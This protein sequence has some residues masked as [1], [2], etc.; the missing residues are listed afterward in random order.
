MLC[1]RWH[2]YWLPLAFFWQPLAVP[3]C[4]ITPHISPPLSLPLPLSRSLHLFS[5]PSPSFSISLSLSLCLSLPLSLILNSL[6]VALCLCV[7]TDQPISHVIYASVFMPFLFFSLPISLPLISLSVSSP[8]C[9]YL[10]VTGGHPVPL[11]SLQ[12]RHMLSLTDM[13][14][15]SSTIP[16]SSQQGGA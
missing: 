12:H 10:C 14:V 15:H 5:S 16:H 11:P 8:G 2:P 6:S 4:R 1:G 9:V 3:H 7:T 13:L